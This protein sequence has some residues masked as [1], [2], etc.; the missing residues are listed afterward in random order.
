MAEKIVLAYSG[1]LDTSV[2][3]HW[4]RDQRGYEVYCLTI[5]LGNLGDL[6]G[7][8]ERGEQAGAAQV[9]IVDAK[10]DFLRYFVFPALQA[11]VVY[12]GRYPL[13]TA[14]GRPLIAKL[15][16]DKAREVGATAVAHGCTGKGNDQ[17][18]LDI[19]VQTLAPDLTIVGTTREHSV[20][21]DEALAYA[22]Q[23]GISVRQSQESPYSTDENLWGRSVEAGVLEDP[24]VEPPADVFLWTKPLDETPARPAEVE[25]RFQ[26][27]IPVALDGVE[28]GPVDLVQRLSDLGGEHGI[29]R[30]DM[31]E[32]RL[33]GI[34]SR[35]IYEAPAAV[36]LL[37]AHSA[38]ESLT[39]TK[40]QTRFKHLVAQE[41]ADLV[42]NGLWFSSHHRDLSQ[43]V[44]STQRHVTG[45]VRVRLWHGNATVI[46]R[47]ADRS[48]YSQA[49]ATYN[50]EGDLF[51]Q[52]HAQGFIRLHGLQAQVQA[53]TQ[54]LTEAGDLLKLAAPEG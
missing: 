28:M 12:E 19:G 18:R 11:G 48:L 2:A 46:G 50:K 47:R 40:P 22:A 5:D 6:E 32:N 51:D 9:D 1:G 27:G 16:V 30:I 49:L 53:Q 44:V 17:V 8:R 13:A 38:L 33:V 21:R 4:L 26:E 42:Y 34:K 10:Q 15:L 43:Y 35:E 20:S 29:G 25:I 14:L 7:I 41:Y 23:H 31:V 37:E 52:S 54:M 24:W 45:D 3:A 36:I 39:L